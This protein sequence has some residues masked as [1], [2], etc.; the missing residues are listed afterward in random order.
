MA[1]LTPMKRQYNEIKQ[2]HTDCLLFFR[3][4][5]FSLLLLSLHNIFRLF[6]CNYCIC[7]IFCSKTCC[8]RSRRNGCRHYSGDREHS[9]FFQFWLNHSWSTSFL[10][11]YRFCSIA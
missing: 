4:L 3:L 5:L 11:L 1:E 9:E 10:L 7:T 8:R 6:F 2:Q